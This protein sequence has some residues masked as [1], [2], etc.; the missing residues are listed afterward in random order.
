VN[1]AFYAAG[2][3]YEDTILVISKECPVHEVIDKPTDDVI[4]GE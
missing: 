4:G 3:A 2:H 1:V